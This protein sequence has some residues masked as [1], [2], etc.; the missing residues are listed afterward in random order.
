MADDE[1]KQEAPLTPKQYQ[2]AHKEA[3]AY[4][5]ANAKARRDA[6]GTLTPTL[7]NRHL[8]SRQDLVLAY[9]R[10][11]LTVTYTLADL[12]RFA[13]R[14]IDVQKRAGAERGMPMLALENAS[15]PV[16]RERAK[17]VKSATLYRIQNGNELFFHVSGNC[18]PHYQVRVRMEEWQR[19]M[20][21]PFVS[22][23]KKVRAALTGRLSFDCQCG[24]HQ[25]WYRYLANIGQYDFTPPVEQAFP[26]IRNPGLTGC[27][28]KHVLKVLQTMRNTGVVAML[29][30]QMDRQGE[31]VGYGKAET[32][33]LTQSELDAVARAKGTAMPMHEARRALSGF[34][35]KARSFLSGLKDSPLGKLIPRRKDADAEMQE[36]IAQ[37]LKAQRALMDSGAA[38]A[39]SEAARQ[40][41]K[42][43]EAQAKRQAEL[44]EQARLKAQAKAEAARRSIGDAQTRSSVIGALRSARAYAK[45]VGVDERSLHGAIRDTFHVTQEQI[46][47][48]LKEI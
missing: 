38:K 29:A 28:C 13:K 23:E 42:A 2:Q 36:R 3:L 35:Q 43:Q 8:K 30:R 4:R 9:G 39:Q 47:A 15:L 24:R 17:T 32:Q 25:F 46:D 1:Q 19:Q 20:Q 22:T 41:K 16:D 48:L 21:R 11:G 6:V 40:A 10:Q 12:Q 34:F 33:N 5:K 7:L 31:L 44:A 14:I 27:C 37:Q 18:R 26:K 45:A